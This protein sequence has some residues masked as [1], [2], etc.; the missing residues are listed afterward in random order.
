[1]N[2]TYTNLTVDEI[3][4]LHEEGLKEWAAANGGLNEVHRYLARAVERHVVG[5]FSEALAGA[6]VAPVFKD[7]RRFEER[8]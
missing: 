8:G 6:P 7:R 3:D 5:K 2:T 1:M 4:R